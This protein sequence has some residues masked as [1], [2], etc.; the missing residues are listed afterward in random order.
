MN[1]HTIQQSYKSCRIYTDNT[2]RKIDIVVSLRI[3]NSFRI[4]FKT[5][6]VDLFTEQVQS[7]TE[8]NL[9][10]CILSFEPIQDPKGS[11]H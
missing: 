1:G 11:T 4:L 6:C 5:I 10:N 9:L 8:S 2:T 3:V 7:I